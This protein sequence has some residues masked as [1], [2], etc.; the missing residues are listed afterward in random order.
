MSTRGSGHCMLALTI[1]AVTEV[2]WKTTH[3][4]VPCVVV[5]GVNR[6]HER[7]WDMA[8]ELSALIRPDMESCRIG[9]S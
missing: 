8:G 9:G 1:P 5:V 7:R 2:R 6:A 4:P 3:R